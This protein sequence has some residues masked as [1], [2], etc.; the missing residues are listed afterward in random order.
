MSTATILNIIFNV[1]SAAGTLLYISYL[2]ST[3][4]FRTD[5]FSGL[6]LGGAAKRSLSN[7]HVIRRRMSVA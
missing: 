6:F 1:S 3:E 7:Q 5:F 2:L 4:Y